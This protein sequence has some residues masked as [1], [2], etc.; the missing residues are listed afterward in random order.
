MEYLNLRLST[1]DGLD[2]GHISILARSLRGETSAQVSRLPFYQDATQWRTTLI[3]ALGAMIYCPEDFPHIEERQWLQTT[4]LLDTTGQYFADSMLTLVGKAV[5]TSLFPGDVHDLLQKTL[6]AVGSGES[7]H[8]QIEFSQEIAPDSRIPDYP[9]ELACNEQGFLCRQNV[10]FS[11]YIAFMDA[12]PNLPP[13]EAIRVLLVSS[14]GYDPDPEIRL[15]PLDNQEQRA[16]VAGFESAQAQGRVTLSQLKLEQGSATFK[17][18]GDY[19]LDHTKELAPH[20]IHFDGHGFF[21]KRCGV[22]RTIHRKLSQ[23]H[24][25]KCQVPLPDSPQGYLVFES[26]SDASSPADYVSAAEFGQLLRDVGLDQPQAHGIRLVVTSAC[27]SGRALGSESVFNGVAQGLIQ[28]GIPA[29][30]AMQH[31]VTVNAAAAFAER[32]YRAISGERTLASALKVAQGAM[33]EPNQWYRPILY[34][35]WPSNEGGQLFLLE[36]AREAFPNQRQADTVSVSWEL[37]AAQRKQWRSAFISAF[38]GVPQLELML[39]DELDVP[40][41]RITQNRSQYDLTVR[42]LIKWAESS[43]NLKCLLEAS[44]RSNPGNPRLQELAAIWLQS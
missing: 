19:L 40:L 20:V 14:A 32:F 29:V 7:L 26:G 12:P 38:P 36:N 41:N 1:P 6:G 5:Y 30:V 22:C 28:H 2:E 17:A 21:G 27:Q 43:G 18:L 42:D 3:K 15:A 4:G 11:R 44:L 35:R 16:V 8:I 23:T 24:C 13:V 37:N 9:W 31:N 25:R 33:T 34:L 39:E 10:T